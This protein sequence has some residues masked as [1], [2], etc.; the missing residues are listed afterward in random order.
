M[1][2]RIFLILILIFI[3]QT[4]LYSNDSIPKEQEFLEFYLQEVILNES[5][6]FY[7]SIEQYRINREQFLKATN[8][9][10]FKDYKNCAKSVSKW[11]VNPFQVGHPIRLK[12][13]HTYK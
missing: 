13:C 9:E 4:F 3:T 11:T 5:E 10:F 6:N 8:I 1:K 7:N 2:T 12:L